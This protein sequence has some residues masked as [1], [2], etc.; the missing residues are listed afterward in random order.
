MPGR[1][2]CSGN[3]QPTRAGLRQRCVRSAR[4]RA[5]SA[6][7]GAVMMAAGALLAGCATQ[8]ST[9]AQPGSAKRSPVPVELIGQGLVL[10]DGSHGPQLCL[11]A[12]AFSL[13]PQCGGP[14]IANWDWNKVS[15]ETSQRATTEGSYVVIGHFDRAAN[16]F[17]L[18]RPA[19]PSAQYQGPP[20]PLEPEP[21]DLGTRCKE[22]AAGWGV[23]DTAKATDASL[24]RTSAR[25][26]QMAGY[27]DLWLDQSRSA[28][29]EANDP[30]RLILNVAFTRD[31]KARERELR[32]TWDGALC[33]SKASRTEDGIERI[34]GQVEKAAGPAALSIAGR[35][36]VVELRVI[37]DDGTLQDDFDRDYGKGVVRV[38]SALS[39]DPPTCVDVA[40]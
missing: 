29:P 19:I 25:A 39:P 34:Q 8:A 6:V 40:A 37:Y 22:P 10:Q 30:R 7:S 26:A 9:G 20:V 35:R 16:V 23:V 36:G 27:A 4:S 12:I 5:G 1:F 15:G 3:R 33:V 14:D 13:P 24:D 21:V 2:T 31:L 18:T 28:N 11:G 17:R 32:K 38:S